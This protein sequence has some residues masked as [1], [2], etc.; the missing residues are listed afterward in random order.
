MSE[1]T[2][3]NQ[4]W[5]A[6]LNT[7]I[8]AVIIII[9]IMTVLVDGHQ[10]LLPILLLVVLLVIARIRG[11]RAHLKRTILDDV[12]PNGGGTVL[13]LVLVHVPVAVHLPIP[14]RAAPN[15]RAPSVAGVAGVL[16]KTIQA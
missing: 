3:D 6:V 12:H 4:L 1:R 16:A 9:I 8:V 2:N 5:I 13:V 10:D 7:A 15:L 14:G 11:T